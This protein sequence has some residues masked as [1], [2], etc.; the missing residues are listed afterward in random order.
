[1]NKKQLIACLMTVF[2]LNAVC[3]GC[4]D[5]KTP[6]QNHSSATDSLE[7]SSNMEST[8]EYSSSPCDMITSS[9]STLSPGAIKTDFLA[10]SKVSSKANALSSQGTSSS[11]QKTGYISKAN[12]KVE[13]TRTLTQIKSMLSSDAMKCDSYDLKKY[14]TPYWNG[15]I[16][17]NESLNF[18]KDPKTGE[19]FRTFVV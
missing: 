7:E 14:T 2:M 5:N 15:N 11:S 17:Y 3:S 12:T 9:E 19:F 8:A 1:M 6:S 13:P 4:S 18:I 10:A 16:V